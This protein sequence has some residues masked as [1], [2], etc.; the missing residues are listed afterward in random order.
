MYFLTCKSESSRKGWRSTGQ[1][2]QV[3]PPFWG[4]KWRIQDKRGTGTLNDCMKTINAT[5]D[6]HVRRNARKAATKPKRLYREALKADVLEPLNKE[7]RDIQ[8]TLS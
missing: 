3:A 1:P 5:T 4:L 7:G 8:P 6:M 2:L